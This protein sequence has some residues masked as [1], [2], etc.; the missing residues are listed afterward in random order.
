MVN[1]QTKKIAYFLAIF[2]A[3][4]FGYEGVRGYQVMSAKASQQ[5]EVTETMQ[6]FK[7]SFMA[8]A[9]SRSKWDKSYHR[10]SSVQDIVSLFALVELEKYGLTTDADS[11]VLSKVEQVTGS[12]AP[13]GLTKICISSGSMDSFALVVQ[14]PNY[15]NLMTGI[16]QLAKRPD[17]YLG[18]IDVKGD[19]QIPIAKLGD[20]CLL[21]RND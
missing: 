20:F 18:N 17:I 14:A 3:L 4:I 13:I 10:E 9:D 15:Q 19:K 7:S 1:A 6:R 11:L 12:N 5:E 21:L 2:G 16:G 8:L